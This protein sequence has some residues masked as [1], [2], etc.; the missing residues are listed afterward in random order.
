MSV[1]AQRSEQGMFSAGARLVEAAPDALVVEWHLFPFLIDQVVQ[2]GTPYSRIVV[3]DMDTILEPGHPQLPVENVY[4]GLPPT[5]VEIEVLDDGG[6][7]ETIF[8]P[9]PIL[10]APQGTLPPPDDPLARP[11]ELLYHYW[12]DP[13]IYQAAWFY[14]GTLARIEGS[15]WMRSQ[16]IA[17]LRIFPFQYAPGRGIVQV[18]R[19]LRLR[20]HFAGPAPL[21]G[22][23]VAETAPFE[24]LFRHQL[25]NAEQAR[26]WRSQAG[27]VS[28]LLSVPASTGQQPAVKIWVDHDALYRLD[29]EVLRNLGVPI[30]EIDLHTLRLERDG[31]EVA[32]WVPDEDPHPG[33]PTGALFFYGQGARSK[34]TQA[35]VYWL[36]W[37]KGIGRRMAERPGMPDPSFPLAESFAATV[38]Q[39][40]NAAY[41]SSLPGGDDLERWYWTYLHSASA[42]EKTFTMPLTA[43]LTDTSSAVL[44]LSLTMG[45]PSWPN[46]YHH[47]LA[48]VNDTYVGEGQW[49]GYSALLLELPFSQEILHEGDNLVRLVAPGDQGSSSDLFFLDWIEITYQRALVVQDDSLHFSLASA[50]PCLVQL[51][52][53]TGPD[54][55]LLDIGDPLAPVRIIGGASEPLG[56]GYRF[57]FSQQGDVAPA[58]YLATTLSQAELPLGV[59]M[60]QPSSWHQPTNGADYLIIAPSE[61]ITAVRPLAEEYAQA[62][63]RTQIVDVQDVYDEFAGGRPDPR[64]IHDFLA[65]AYANWT[66]P[67]PTYVLL[68]G[69][70]HYDFKGYLGNGMPNPIPPYLANVDPWILETAADNRFVRLVGDDPLADMLL[71]RLPVN[72]PS[73]AAAVVDKILAYRHMADLSAWQERVL[74]VADNADGAGNFPVLS[75]E[76]AND[77]LP[78]IYTADKVY[79]GV[80]YPYE[81]PAV[82]AR[83]AIIGAVNEGRLVVNYIGHGAI[84]YLAAERLL[85]YEHVAAL[86]N[87]P[88]LPLFLSWS[89]YSGLYA[90]PNPSSPAI[91][92]VWTRTPANGAIAAWV[93]TGL[94]LAWAH[95][96]M[97]KGVFEA[98]FRDDLTTLG[99]AA[100]AGNLRLY[101]AAPSMGYQLDTYVLL[102]DPALGLAVPLTDLGWEAVAAAPNPLPAGQVVTLTATL[103]NLGPSPARD[104]TLQADLPAGWSLEQYASDGFTMTLLSPDPPRWALADLPAGSAGTVTILF[105]SG[106]EQGNHRLGLLVE[107]AVRDL[108]PGNN[109][110]GVEVKVTESL[111]ALIEVRMEPAVVPV[112]GQAVVYVTVL[113][114][115]GHPVADGTL[116]TVA[117]TQGRI[118]PSSAQT[119][120]GNVTVRFLAQSKGVAW[121]TAICGSIQGQASVQIVPSL[122]NPGAS[123]RR[124]KP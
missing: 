73:E 71:G 44:R 48:Y 105:R 79:L 37:E 30:D 93:P 70:G 82:T 94:G 5:E 55:L 51:Q 76:I 111:P 46:P 53:F 52:S 58:V 89:C 15:G 65:Y 3:P 18:Y 116:V 104:V 62:G 34:F 96:Y 24:A 100:L 87:G 10:P 90:V 103:F 102:G 35:N 121:V 49:Y 17:L 83:N 56:E 20:L 97:N 85:G 67:A 33:A 42:R 47:V 119:V 2:D 43:P 88:A 75:D 57:T 108:D 107:S 8:L 113:D 91:G 115:A 112:G 54:I 31:Q 26:L 80:N 86:S 74:F 22:P 6:G 13:G 41:L 114:A 36:T 106:L 120:G 16:H 117:A 23:T 63:L 123:A 50:E 11:E 110:V 14:P 28:M 72:S 118:M 99:L 77:Y 122:A 69:D 109:A 101:Q 92:E 29:F 98:L 27:P 84:P 39:E 7:P 25:L 21:N 45:V 1:Q 4:L 40:V 68:V 61:M 59:E 19:Y 60:E 38:H 66:P 81:N 124:G 12:P 78:P 9:W 32:L 95:H 64:A